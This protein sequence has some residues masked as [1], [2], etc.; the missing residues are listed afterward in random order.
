MI[1]PVLMGTG[2]CPSQGGRPPEPGAAGIAEATS[3]PG[4]GASLLWCAAYDDLQ[5]RQPRLPQANDQDAGSGCCVDL[6]I[7]VD[8]GGYLTRAD[9]KGY[10]LSKT[11]GAVVEPGDAHVAAGL[12]GSTDES[13]CP[14]LADLL[15]RLLDATRGCWLAELRVG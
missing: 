2:F 12:I 10:T 11:F 8:P 7:E 14:T 15:A 3:W 4:Q 9:L 5:V 1:D 6:M 13:A